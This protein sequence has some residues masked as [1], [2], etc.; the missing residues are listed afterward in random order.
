MTAVAQP[1]R[2]PSSSRSAKP[3]ASASGNTYRILKSRSAEAARTVLDG[4]A[5][6]LVTDG[7][8][9][10]QS[11]RDT[12][13]RERAGPVVLAHCWAHVRRTFHDA[14]PAWPQ[15]TEMLEL[16]GKL[17]AVEAEVWTSTAMRVALGSPRCGASARSRSSTR[18]R[19][20]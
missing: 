19:R 17:Y 13:A 15:T 8:A 5:G 18:S 7:Y 12:L 20:G 2:W 11:M 10:Y 9:A 14:E 16:I 6:I 4:F 3:S 1:R